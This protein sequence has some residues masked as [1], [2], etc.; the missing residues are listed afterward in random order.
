[1][2]RRNLHLARTRTIPRLTNIMRRVYARRTL[3]SRRF[4]RRSPSIRVAFHRLRATLE[5]SV[6]SSFR[7]LPP[8]GSSL[9]LLLSLGTR[10]THGGVQCASFE[11]CNYIDFLGVACCR[12]VHAWR[13]R[14]DRPA[15]CV[16]DNETECVSRGSEARGIKRISRARARVAARSW[17]RARCY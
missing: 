8:F 14:R 3:T 2:H 1:M 11:P 10:I 9:S 5:A 6:N 7:P 13:V 12:R 17:G 16:Y 15:L 4:Y